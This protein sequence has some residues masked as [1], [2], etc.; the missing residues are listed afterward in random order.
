MSMDSLS[1]DMRAFSSIFL[2]LSSPAASSCSSSSPMAGV[3][4]AVSGCS[5]I[6][7]ATDPPL[8]AG[9]CAGMAGHTIRNRVPSAQR[10]QR[11]ALKP[12][13][14]LPVPVSRPG[15]YILFLIFK[16]TARGRE[17]SLHFPDGESDSEIKSLSCGHRTGKWY[18]WDVNQ[19]CWFQRIGVSPL[20][21][22]GQMSVEQTC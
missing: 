17:D 11:R 4:T 2:S 10:L 19:V 20:A 9:R 5:T 3:I 1:Q 22:S 18:T 6:S 8:L 13:S 21:S 7:G 16:T 14:R 15:P 12:P